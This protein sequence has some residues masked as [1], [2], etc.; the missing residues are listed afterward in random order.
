MPA[1]FVYDAVRT[2][3]A[4]HGTALPAVSPAA[5]KAASAA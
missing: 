4:G 2:P 5:S 3:F 1:S